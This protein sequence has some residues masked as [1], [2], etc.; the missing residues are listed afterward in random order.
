[1]SFC[2]CLIKKCY[3]CLERGIGS[4]NLNIVRN[5]ERQRSPNLV[6]TALRPQLLGLVGDGSSSMN[7]CL[8][9]SLLSRKRSQLYLLQFWEDSL[10]ASPD[11][12]VAFCYFCQHTHQHSFFK[13][14]LWKWE[15]TSKVLRWS[16]FKVAIREFKILFDPALV[17]RV[18][19]THTLR[20]R[21]Q[22]YRGSLRLFFC[23]LK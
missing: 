9:C 1:M 15:S 14:G 7:C 23:T 12:Q 21:L 19:M 3:I 17:T 18:I 2:L 10:F 5:L 4:W 16:V 8:L 13:Q 11:S 6:S 20:F 22:K